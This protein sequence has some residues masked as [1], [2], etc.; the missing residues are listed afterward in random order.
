MK[1]YASLTSP[2]ARKV[3]IVLIEKDIDHALVEVDTTAVDSPIR[4]LNPLGKVPA[5][6]RD[7]G[8][9]LFDSPLIVEWL[10]TLGGKSL[11]PSSGEPRFLALL[12]QALADGMMD[13]AVSRTTE[14]RR[15][16]ERRSPVALAHQEGK[17]ARA[18]DWAEARVQA[19]F[20]VGG[21]LSVADVALVA[22]LEYVDFR[23]PHDWRSGHPK[24]ALYCAKLA[25]RPSFARTRPPASSALP[26]SDR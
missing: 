12:W 10:D 13:A 4:E 7:D 1:L 11:L 18:M 2:Y 19:E 24:L 22:A 21:Q 17:V 5:L 9:V 14:M 8:S 20:L 3:R 16:P 26:S 23:H 25:E 6:E 15:S